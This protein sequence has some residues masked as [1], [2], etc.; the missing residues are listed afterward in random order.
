MIYQVLGIVIGIAGII[1]SFARFRES[2]TS[3]GG[4]LLWLILWVSV[5]MFSLNPPLSTRIA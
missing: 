4:L 1:V 5:I 3:P 2:R